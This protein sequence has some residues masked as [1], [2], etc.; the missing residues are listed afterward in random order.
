MAI[1]TD[2]MDTERLASPQ[3]WDLAAVLR[4]IIVFG[5]V[6]SAFALLT[7]FVLRRIF[8]ADERTFQTA[9]F[10]AVLGLCLRPLCSKYSRPHAAPRTRLA[11]TA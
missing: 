7:F 11:S 2:R 9:W 4:F 10:V 6:R 5:L 1:S 3:R 8:H